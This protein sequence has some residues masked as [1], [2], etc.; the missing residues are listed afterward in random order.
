MK[1][2]VNITLAGDTVQLLD[3]VSKPGERS[4]IIDRAIKY[5]VEEIGERNLRRQLKEGALRG[6]E[7]DLSLA[8]EWFSVDEEAWSR[9]GR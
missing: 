2:R 6:A 8:S 3:R 7:R 1:K 4:N 9:K 5:Y